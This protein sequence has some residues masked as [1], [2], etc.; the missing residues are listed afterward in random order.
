MVASFIN[1]GLVSL[2]FQVCI[3]IKYASTEMSRT[4]V[5]IVHSREKSEHWISY[6][7]GRRVGRAYQDVHILAHIAFRVGLDNLFDCRSRVELLTRCH[8]DG[9]VRFDNWKAECVE[10]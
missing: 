9:I 7:P 3:L 5:G 6:C 4:S 1:L 2:F 10:S 8:C